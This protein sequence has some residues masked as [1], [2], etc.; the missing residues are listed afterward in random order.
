[1]SHKV[2]GFKVRKKAGRWQI[3]PGSIA[4]RLRMGSASY[5][6]NLLGSVDSELWA[7]INSSGSK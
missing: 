3:V 4:D 6:S 7:C 1:M 5:I 2:T